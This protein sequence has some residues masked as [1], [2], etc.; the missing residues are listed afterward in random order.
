MASCWQGDGQPTV[1]DAVRAVRGWATTAAE[2]VELLRRAGLSASVIA[3]AIS[4]G[5]TA[6]VPFS[7]EGMVDALCV[8]Q[9]GREF[10][11]SVGPARTARVSRI[12]PLRAEIPCPMGDATPNAIAGLHHQLETSTRCT[13]RAGRRYDR[14]SV[15]R[16]RQEQ[17]V[18][19][20]TGQGHEEPGPPPVK[21]TRTP[22]SV[23]QLGDEY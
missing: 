13:L 4:A 5:D 10:F 16:W 22:I 6:S 9:S 20:V 12:R 3:T 11:S 1:V 2:V 7:R 8:E 23:R 14:P 18:L 17:R 19:L 15:P 21:R